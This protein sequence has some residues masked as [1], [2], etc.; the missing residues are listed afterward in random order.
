MLVELLSKCTMAGL[1][2]RVG[3]QKLQSLFSFAVQVS[4]NQASNFSI[5]FGIQNAIQYEST[6]RF[7]R[8]P[9]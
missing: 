6:S 5:V 2:C 4:I 9:E 7:G 3:H 8:L 1:E